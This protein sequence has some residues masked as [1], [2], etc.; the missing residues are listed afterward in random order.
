MSIKDSTLG[1]AL[2]AIKNTPSVVME[3]LTGGITSDTPTLVPYSGAKPA[4][5]MVASLKA[6]AVATTGGLPNWTLFL[7][8][9][10]ALGAAA[11]FFIFKGKKR[12]TRR[13]RR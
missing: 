4:S 2:V 8:S 10:L 6:S 3:S 13:R 7:G 9:L 11:Y 5:G 1:E 12:T